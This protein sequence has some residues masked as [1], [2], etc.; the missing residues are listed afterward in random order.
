[1]LAGLS[2]KGIRPAR[3]RIPPQGEKPSLTIQDG[4]GR[5]WRAWYHRQMSDI[6]RCDSPGCSAESFLDDPSWLFLSFPQNACP[7]CQDESCPGARSV[8]VDLC[9]WKCLSEFVSARMLIASVDED[10]SRDDTDG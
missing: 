9:S 8:G 5:R 7:D 4:P 3:N 10:G 2:R 1:M 6:T